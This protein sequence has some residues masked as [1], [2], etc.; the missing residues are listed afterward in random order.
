ME[1]ISEQALQELRQGYTTTIPYPHKVIDNFFKPEYLEN[2]MK[3]INSLNNKNADGIFM[4]KDWEYKK[5]SFDHNFEPLLKD[6]FKQLTEDAFIQEMEQCTGISNLVRGDSTL[7]GA[8][9]HRV[10]RDGLLGLHTD[11]NIYRGMDRRINMLV[12]LNPDWKEEY[13]GSFL[14]CDKEQK[15]IV[16][17]IYPFYNR[18]VIFSTTKDS[19]HGHPEPLTCP[20]DMKRQSIAIYYYTRNQHRDRSDF[21][22]DKKHNTIFYKFS[23]FSE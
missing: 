1:Y 21:E 7:H 3:E 9:V 2:I 18:C 19:I 8:G 11:F 10:E 16:N 6:I 5:Y 23:D 12:Y 22:G 15:K 13:N 17:R 20:P 4:N 14:V